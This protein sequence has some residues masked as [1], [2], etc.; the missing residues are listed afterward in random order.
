MR[1]AV[2]KKMRGVLVQ[3]MWRVKMVGGVLMRRIWRVKMKKAERMWHVEPQEVGNVW[4][5][6]AV[7]WALL[8]L[9]ECVESRWHAAS[10]L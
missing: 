2:A 8:L 1:C 7:V 10:C 6:K 5:R 9:E 3:R 4:E